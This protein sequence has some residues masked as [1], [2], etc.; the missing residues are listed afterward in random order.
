MIM[1]TKRD[2]SQTTKFDFS[3]DIGHIDLETTGLIPKRQD[4]A[5]EDPCSFGDVVQVFGSGKSP[6]DLRAR[7][8]R[9]RL[10]DP[11]AHLITG[12]KV[13]TVSRENLT[14]YH[15]SKRVMAWLNQSGNAGYAAFNASYENKYLMELFEKNLIPDRWIFS[16]KPLLDS[17]L[18]SLFA[19]L[20][21]RIAIG[22]N[23][24]NLPSTK[25]EHL[26]E[27]NQIP[28]GG[29]DAKQDAICDR[30]LFGLTLDNT[31]ELMEPIRL[32]ISGR[33]AYGEHLNSAPYILEAYFACKEIRIKPLALM[34]HPDGWNHY[35]LGISLMDSILDSR[36]TP[37]VVLNQIAKDC[38]QRKN[39]AKSIGI[40]GAGEFYIRSDNELAQALISPSTHAK[41]LDRL[42][43]LRQNPVLQKAMN[44]GFATRFSG[45][46]GA[47]FTSRYNESVAKRFHQA[48]PQSK[49]ALIQEFDHPYEKELASRIIWDNYPDQLP[50]AEQNRLN[51]FTW[52]SWHDESIPGPTINQ[53]WL[54]I[55]ALLSVAK[56]QRE[57]D[58][59]QDYQNYLVKIERRGPSL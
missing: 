49:W 17:R 24:E 56:N 31:P 27:A 45:S 29:H 57:I 53:R 16:R 38:S 48:D 32:K 11:K 2:P 28:A 25:L 5:L 14:Q 34:Q 50:T 47:R 35:F 46:G 18:P 58:I 9:E 59:L 22:R 6:L 10:P 43:N 55:D 8:K 13:S 3:N 21:G 19:I 41:Y 54:E 39:L 44:T 4:I 15:L 12:V 42:K 7:F 40:G 52:A 37:E 23:S 33:K 1:E 51:E 30:S 36:E 20:A 26:A